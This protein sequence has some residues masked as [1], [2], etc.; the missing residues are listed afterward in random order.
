MHQPIS[1]ARNTV[2]VLSD[3]LTGL[4]TVSEPPERLCN[5]L[6][7]DQ[8]LHIFLVDNS[9]EIGLGMGNETA[10][11]IQ[12]SLAKLAIE[13]KVNAKVTSLDAD[14]VILSN[15]EKFESNTVIWTTGRRAN[16]LTTQFLVKKII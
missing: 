15:G 7:A 1:K 5:I 11:I 12:D 9:H 10:T 14:G 16:R 3:D 13:S 2:I 4:E 6:D 8:E